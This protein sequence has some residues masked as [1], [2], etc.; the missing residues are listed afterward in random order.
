MD[1]VFINSENSKTSD[2]HRLLLNL[3]DKTNLKRRD[4]FV[5]LS[6]L[7]TYYTWKKYKKSHAKTINLKRI[8]E[9]G[10]PAGSYSVSDIEDYFEY[11][12][13]KHGEKTHYASYTWIKYKIECVM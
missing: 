10:L 5:A 8:E 4:K 1:T 2:F 3:L 9:F 12:L 11:V 13:E 6:N 7:S